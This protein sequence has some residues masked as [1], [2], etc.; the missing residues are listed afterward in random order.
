[1]PTP[2]KPRTTVTAASIILRTLTY[3]TGHVR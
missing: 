1:M 2:S 3:T